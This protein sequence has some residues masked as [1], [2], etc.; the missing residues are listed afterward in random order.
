MN[1]PERL[2]VLIIILYL[3]NLALQWVIISWAVD[4]IEKKIDKL[5]KK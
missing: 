3:S 5:N 4:R 1:E 2:G